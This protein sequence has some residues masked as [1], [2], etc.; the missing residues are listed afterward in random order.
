[1]RIPFADFFKKDDLPEKPS[2]A[3]Q[4]WSL[5]SGFSSMHLDA[6]NPDQL[7]RNKGADIYRKMLRDP[8]VK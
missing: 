3:E 2:T 8:Q 6:Y 1:M 4:A 5:D 7:V